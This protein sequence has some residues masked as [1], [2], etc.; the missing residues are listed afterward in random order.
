MLH[1]PKCENLVFTTIRTSKESHLCWKKHFHK[2]P[3]NFRIYA[4]FEADNEKGSSIMGN[5]TTK[6]INKNQYLMVIIYYLNWKMF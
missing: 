1:K 4:D 6:L 2:K 3:L 5:K